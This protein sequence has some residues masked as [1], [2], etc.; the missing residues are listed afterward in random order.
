M[1]PAD[2]SWL[3]DLK[4]LLE[5]NCIS[6]KVTAVT[7]SSGSELH[8]IRWPFAEEFHYQVNGIFMA[9]VLEKPN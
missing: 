1:Q 2:A 8:E 7:N 6:L 9:N 4:L 5:G 3:R